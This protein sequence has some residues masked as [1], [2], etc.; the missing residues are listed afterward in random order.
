MTT[1]APNPND[2]AVVVGVSRYKDAGLNKLT[3]PPNDADRFADWLRHPDRGGLEPDHVRLV[4]NPDGQAPRAV[5][6]A[7]AITSILSTADLDKEKVGRRFYLFLA[8]HGAGDENEPDDV[9]L[10]PATY[11]RSDMYYIV[12]RRWVNALA[13]LGAFDEFVLFMDCCR[14]EEPVTPLSYLPMQAGADGGAA[15]M[16]NVKLCT[17]YATWHGSKAREKSFDGKVAGV[18]TQALMEALEDGALVGGKLTADHLANYVSFRVRDLRDTGSN[19]DAKF[20]NRDEGILLR[21]IPGGPTAKTLVRVRLP[22][23]QHTLAV[24]RHDDPDTPLQVPQQPVAPGQVELKLPS[25]RLYR[26]VRHDAAGAPV[27]EGTVWPI[28]G[29]EVVLDL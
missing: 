25:G 28:V 13:R 10:L 27:G 26:F 22:D 21:N 29:K 4:P 11:S 1:V 7:D 19:Q 18:F 23:P 15:V 9:G 8:G 16:K 3:G 2:H 17:G 24:H 14:V 20:P 6:I 5:D 12:G